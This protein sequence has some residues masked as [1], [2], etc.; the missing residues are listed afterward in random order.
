MFRSGS[1]LSLAVVLVACGDQEIDPSRCVECVDT[2]AA[3]LPTDWGFDG[4]YTDKFLL[5]LQSAELV[6]PA[7]IAVLPT[8][9][10]TSR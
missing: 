8:G 7:L 9:H 10:V 5:D 2:A 3:P 1:V 6:Q 4:V